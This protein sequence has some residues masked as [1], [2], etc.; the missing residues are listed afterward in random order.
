VR[1]RAGLD[2]VAEKPHT[3]LHAYSNLINLNARQTKCN[4]ITVA[5]IYETSINV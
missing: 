1:K 2:A 4:V 5:D 3:D